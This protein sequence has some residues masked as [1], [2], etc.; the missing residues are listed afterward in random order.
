MENQVT[1]MLREA[2]EMAEG[3]MDAKY[4]DAFYLSRQ[5]DKE[6]LSPWFD[7]TLKDLCEPMF[8]SFGKMDLLAD[9]I[10]NK[11]LA[12]SH[13]NNIYNYV[14]GLSGGADSSVCFAILQKMKKLDDRI[15]IHGVA[16]P[17]H[18][19]QAETNL[20]LELGNFYNVNVPVVDLSAAYDSLRAGVFATKKEKGTKIREGNLRARLRMSYLYNLA[21]EVG[22]VVLSTD[23][24]S[25]YTAGFW[26][27]NGDVGDIAPLRNLYKSVDVPGLGRHLN[28]PEKF[29]RVTPTDG[30]GIS[31]SDEDQL[32]MSYLEW[33]ILSTTFMAMTAVINAHFQIKNNTTENVEFDFPTILQDILA[34]W[35]NV[36]PTDAD[37]EKIVK[38]LERVYGSWF[39]RYGGINVTGFANMIKLF[40]ESERLAVIPNSVL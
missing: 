37:V 32:G 26:T 25:E 31:N 38:F 17:I 18:Q 33:D 30:L 24:F 5:S 12:Y 28:L 35:P 27:I 1:K 10:V 11:M 16:L 3:N 9:T 2:S 40:E 14:M 34:I 19:K 22:G 36:K 20:A 4:E 39:K 21:H 8:Y 23:N 6:P 29:W 7:K 13:E 15:T